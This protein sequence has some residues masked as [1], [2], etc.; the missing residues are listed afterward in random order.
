MASV[1]YL[2]LPDRPTTWLRHV[3][4]D[5]A[6]ELGDKYPHRVYDLAQPPARQ[7]NGIRVVVEAGGSF[8]TP[9]MIDEAAAQGVNFWQIIGT[10]INHVAVDRFQRCGIR[11]ANLPGAF[12]SVALAEHALFGMLFFAKNYIESRRALSAGVICD[13]VNEE[14][15]GKTLSLIGFGASG[16]ELAQRAFSFG[17]RVMAM[18]LITPDPAV[19][20]NINCAFFG[21]P[22]DFDLLLSEADYLSIHVPLNASTQN[23]IDRRAL[24]LMKPTA[25]LI[26]VARSEVVEEQALIDALQQ[27][28][29][30]GAALD[31]FLEEPVNAQHPLLR[32][33]NVLA[34]PH[35][36]GVTRET[37]RRRAAA[38]VANVLRVCGGDDPEYLVTDFSTPKHPVD[39]IH[40][41][42]QGLPL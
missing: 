18:D 8:A 25:V 30:R 31:V 35:T 9:E 41:G 6:T 36:A 29:L 23:L 16:Q 40:V 3:Y 33:E 26:N 21:G 22:K 14:L 20:S 17:V 28:R 39:E 38:A 11:L 32:F 15:S 34:T 13:P 1:L 24:S 42:S 5:F 37:S 12:S 2:G 19:L 10:G 7:F 4:S 27:R